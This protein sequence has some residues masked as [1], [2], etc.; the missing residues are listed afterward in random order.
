[1]WSHHH[2]RTRKRQP[3]IFVWKKAKIVLQWR[4]RT[5]NHALRKCQYVVRNWTW[6]PKAAARNVVLHLFLHPN[7][8][9]TWSRRLIIRRRCHIRLCPQLQRLLWR[10]RPINV[11]I[12]LLATRMVRRTRL[13][14]HSTVLFIGHVPDNICPKNSLVLLC[15]YCKC[16]DSSARI[17]HFSLKRFHVH[18]YL[19]FIGLQHFSV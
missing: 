4:R 11:S 6:A 15:N 19:V 16:T 10:L 1:M 17:F 3:K 9:P 8:R 18:D 2:P 7:P 5:G 12:Q 13:T 14:A